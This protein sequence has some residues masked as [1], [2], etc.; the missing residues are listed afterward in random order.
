KFTGK[1]KALIM[2]EDEEEAIELFEYRIAEF[3]EEEEIQ[4]IGET[5][6]NVIVWEADMDFDHYTMM[7]N[8]IKDKEKAQVIHVNG[9][10]E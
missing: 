5:S 2:A 9:K 3:D 7:R 10:I 6:A 8:A 4:R 1:N